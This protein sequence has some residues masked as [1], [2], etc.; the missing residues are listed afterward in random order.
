[1]EGQDLRGV[2]EG[3][4]SLPCICKLCSIG[5][6]LI[7]QHVLARCEDQRW[8]QPAQ[9]L[10]MDRAHV[11]L[12]PILNICTPE[13]PVTNSLRHDIWRFCYTVLPYHKDGITA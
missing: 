4:H 8:W 2:L 1:M 9:I 5:L 6:G 3:S 11:R 13:I 10:C 12:L 7:H